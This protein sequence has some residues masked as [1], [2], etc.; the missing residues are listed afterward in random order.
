MLPTSGSILLS[1]DSHL[2]TVPRLTP[3]SLAAVACEMPNTCRLR[4]RHLV[5][6]FRRIL[7]AL[8]LS[9]LLTLPM[10]HYTMKSNI[11][12]HKLFF[13]C[14]DT[15]GD[16]G[17]SLLHIRAVCGRMRRFLKSRYPY[18]DLYTGPLPFHSGQIDR[19]IE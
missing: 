3:Q 11:C 14:K 13:V 18:T 16:G 17:T 15:T 12:S 5:F 1:G 8:C 6:A 4:Y 9:M 7:A 10:H 2:A 19:Q